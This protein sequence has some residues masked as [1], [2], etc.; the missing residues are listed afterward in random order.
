MRNDANS[1]AFRLV[2]FD[3]GEKKIGPNGDHRLVCNVE[4]G[5]KIAI[6]GRDHSRRNIE[7]VLEAGIPCKIECDHRLPEPWGTQYGHTHWVPEKARLRIVA[8]GCT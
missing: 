8:E 2:G 1:G 4:G 5:G 6:W 3:E 7:A